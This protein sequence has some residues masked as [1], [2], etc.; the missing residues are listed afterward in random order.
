MGNGTGR[1]LGM[2]R[3]ISEAFDMAREVRAQ[4]SQVRLVH[5]VIPG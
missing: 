2:D 1:Q 3:V 5:R 4:V